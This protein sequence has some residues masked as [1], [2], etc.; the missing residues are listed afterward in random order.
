MIKGI[1]SIVSVV[2]AMALSII[3]LMWAGYW[4]TQGVR[5]AG[6]VGV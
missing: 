6:G 1:V 3:P 5:L 2:V 4:V